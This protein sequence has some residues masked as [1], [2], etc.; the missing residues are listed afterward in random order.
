MRQPG[1]QRQFFEKDLAPWIGRFFADQE[2][3]E[4]ADFYRRVG[5]AGRVFIEIETEA[6]ATY[7]AGPDWRLI[8][9]FFGP[10]STC[11]ITRL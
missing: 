1:R 4:S 8:G 9:A 5:A 7:I 6:F 2:T 11:E 10:F 3:A